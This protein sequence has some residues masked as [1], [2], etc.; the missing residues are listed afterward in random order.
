MVE[1]CWDSGLEVRE[2][3]IL[4]KTKLANITKTICL[5]V[6]LPN[7]CQIIKKTCLRDTSLENRG[8][9][10]DSGLKVPEGCLQ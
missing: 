3:W 8:G 1:G 6:F 10:G 9:G 2:G 7:I 4:C 5:Q